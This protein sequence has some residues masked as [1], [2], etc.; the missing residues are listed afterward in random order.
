M[1]EI[2]LSALKWALVGGLAIIILQTVF[3]LISAG[4]MGGIWGIIVYLPLLFI[5]IWGGISIRR[6]N[7]G[8][9]RFAKSFV[10]V[11]IIAAVGSTLFNMY[12]YEIWMKLIDPEFLDKAMAIAE[13][14]IRD[15]ADKRGMTDEQIEMQLKFIKGMNWEKWGF[16]ISA[17][18]SVVLSLIVAVFVSRPD[19]ENPPV[20]KI[21]G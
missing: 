7:G 9:I 2:V 18:C 19:K 20:I 13:E 3:L 21:E 16:I 12:V 15:V 8:D 14:K 1:K 6:E 11:F 4:M 5:M 17:V 10:A